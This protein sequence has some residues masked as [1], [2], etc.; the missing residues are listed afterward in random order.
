[1]RQFNGSLAVRAKPG[2]KPSLFHTS[3]LFVC[4]FVGFWT[5]FFIGSIRIGGV[6]SF[7]VMWSL[8]CSFFVLNK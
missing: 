3:F 8:I 1:M 4:R 2:A 5:V 7:G 6:L